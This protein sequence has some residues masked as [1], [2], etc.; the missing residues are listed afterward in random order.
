MSVEYAFCFLNLKIQGT[1][2]RVQF[3]YLIYK[4]E[5]QTKI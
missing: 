4:T 5:Q 3:L 1:F 2:I